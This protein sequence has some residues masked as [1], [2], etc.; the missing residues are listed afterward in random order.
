[1]L[2]VPIQ[3]LKVRQVHKEQ[4]EHKVHKV[5]TQELK[6]LKVRQDHKEPKVHKVL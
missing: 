1:V 4:R 6:E 5:L 3:E 2:K